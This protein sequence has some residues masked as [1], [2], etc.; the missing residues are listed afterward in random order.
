METRIEIETIAGVTTKTRKDKGGH[1]VTIVQFEARI[2][3][4]D[5]ERLHHLQ[6]E[7]A[8]LF[9]DIGTKQ[10]HLPFKDSNII[11]GD[12]DIY[13]DESS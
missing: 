13:E 11:E 7:N 4:S 2:T 6:E 8:P 10:N 12:N 9:A 3:A 5:L 1:L